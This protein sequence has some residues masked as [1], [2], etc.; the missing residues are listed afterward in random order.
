MLYGVL[1]RNIRFASSI[2]IIDFILSVGIV[3]SHILLQR[4]H[5]FNGVVIDGEKTGFFFIIRVCDV[6]SSSARLS[7]CVPF[8]FSLLVSIVF[9]YRAYRHFYWHRHIHDVCA[10]TPNGKSFHTKN[11]IADFIL[12]ESLAFCMCVGFI[13]IYFHRKS[14]FP[15]DACT[16]MINRAIFFRFFFRLVLFAFSAIFQCELHYTVVSVLPVFVFDFLFALLH[17][18]SPRPNI[19]CQKLSSGCH[20]VLHCI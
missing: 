7:K 6:L 15:Q 11:S 20:I 17:G 10:F 16:N 13:I 2:H 1:C 12:S 3:H 19:V 18:I 14:C 4:E 8:F 9:C 5:N